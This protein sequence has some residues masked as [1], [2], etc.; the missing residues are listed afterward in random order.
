M[1]KTA[2]CPSCGAPVTF[3][4][5]ASIFAVCEFCQSTLVRH[6][7]NIE[8]IGKMAALVEDRSPLQMGSEGKWNGVHFALIGRIQLRYSQG[9]W[10]EWYI[11]FDDMRT[12]WLSEASGEYVLSFLKF[13]PE[14]LPAF[15]DIQVG[16]N[17]TLLNRN[18]QITNIED[19]ECIA[20]QGELPFKVGAGYKAPVVD[21]REGDNFATLDYS[22]SPP[23]L[24]VGAPVKFEALAMA[25]LRDL[26]AGG[27]IP[28]INVQA[29]VFRCPSCGSPL[30]ARSADIKSV[31]C[32][33]CGAVVDTSDK[34]YQLL[35]KALN[36]EDDRYAPRIAIGSKGKLEGKPVEVIGFMVK[37]QMCDGI[38]YD[39][40]EYLLAGENGTYR[41]LTEYNNH[42]N[43][44]DV[45]S[46][47]PHST[48]KILAQ[49]NYGGQQFKHFS[50]YQGRVIQV[51]GEFT[52]RVARDDVAELV[53]YI[54]PPL[55]LSRERTDTEISWSLCRYIEPAVVQEAFKLPVLP[56][57]QGVYANQPSPWEEKHRRTSRAFWWMALVALVVQLLMVFAIGGGKLVNQEVVFNPQSTDEIFTSREFSLSG[58][59]NKVTVTSKAS[60]N[61]NWISL[62]MA[63]INKTT[64]TAWPAVREISYYSG[65]DG[66]ESWSEGS[67]QDDVA[68]VDIPSGKY[69]LTID[70]ELSPE[71]QSPVRLTLQAET[72]SPGWSNYVMVMIFLMIFPIWSRIRRSGFE[73]SRWA[74]SDYAPDSDEDDDE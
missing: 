65:V 53:D 31:G 24:F 70:P 61:N 45:L 41:W 33:S 37:R 8:D 51:A 10:N 32:A 14:P 34:N 52:W 58:G 40:R 71:T 64:G 55:M 2:S 36:P 9:L 57:P 30:S 5:A 4:S 46:K 21:L 26:T 3:K 50:T 13:A 44:A 20:G 29:Q 67:N 22:E 49:F 54:A 74:E 73:S 63:L 42:W 15:T 60:L 56:E 48:P 17:L 38:A 28:D 66:G 19:A 59:G 11:M 16:N 69:V 43:V 23:L 72:A 12:G 1:A 6:D 62:N 27:A 18:W 47:H 25:N 35:S 68:F 39:W 7:Q